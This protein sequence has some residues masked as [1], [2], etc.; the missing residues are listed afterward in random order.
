MGFCSSTDSPDEKINLT[1]TKEIA[2][3]VNNEQADDE[4]QPEWMREL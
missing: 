1:T 3:L 2:K 4:E